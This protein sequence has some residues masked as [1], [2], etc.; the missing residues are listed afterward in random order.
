VPRP[1]DER[2]LLDRATPAPGLPGLLIPSPEDHAIL[3][4]IHAATH[5]FEHP[6]ALLDVELLLRRGLDVAALAARA[7]SCRAGTVMFILMRALRELG[8]ASVTDAH[9]AAFDPGPLRRALLDRGRALSGADQ[10]L[11]LAWIVRQTPLRDDLGGWALGVLRYA[12]LRGVERLL[13]AK[14]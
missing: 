5:D 13:F 6:A 11:G 2:A 3:I 4:A 1:V 12:A 7:R 10:A 8:A 14:A 9:V